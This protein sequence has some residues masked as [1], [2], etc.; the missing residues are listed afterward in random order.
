M[1][2]KVVQKSSHRSFNLNVKEAFQNGQKVTKYFGYL[3]LK[4]YRQ[5]N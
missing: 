1:I 3:W 2:T 5:K 4:I